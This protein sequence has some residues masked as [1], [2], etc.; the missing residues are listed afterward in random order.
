MSTFSWTVTSNRS[1]NCLQNFL[2]SNAFWEATRES[3]T[4]TAVIRSVSFSFLMKMVLESLAGVNPLLKEHQEPWD[5]TKTIRNNFFRTLYEIKYEKNCRNTKH[6]T[7]YENFFFSYGRKITEKQWPKYENMIRKRP[8]E[9]ENHT[10]I[11]S[12]LRKDE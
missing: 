7:E 4:K 6:M 5:H 12:T 2:H 3:S 8:I 9:Y 1:A 11:L 10:K